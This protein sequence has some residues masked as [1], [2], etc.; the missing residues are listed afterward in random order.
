MLRR[1]FGWLSITWKSRQLKKSCE[2]NDLAACHLAKSRGSSK[3]TSLK[4]WTLFLTLNPPLVEA[5]RLLPIKTVE[6]SK[7]TASENAH[8]HILSILDTSKVI[9]LS[10]VRW[11]NFVG[12]VAVVRFSVN[13]YGY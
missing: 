1:W 9:F 3:N 6:T 12:G 10:S 4:V 5:S 11:W 13:S 8:A 2:A 7:K